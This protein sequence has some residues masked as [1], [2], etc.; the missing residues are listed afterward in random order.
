[1]KHGAVKVVPR[2]VVERLMVPMGRRTHGRK[3]TDC[4]LSWFYWVVLSSSA[5]ALKKANDFGGRS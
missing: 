4:Q 2:I 5:P 1:M 3:R